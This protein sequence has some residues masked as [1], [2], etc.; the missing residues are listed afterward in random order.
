MPRGRRAGGHGFPLLD[1]PLVCA[2]RVTS[3]TS[4]ILKHKCFK[5]YKQEDCSDFQN[6]HFYK[7][8]SLKNLGLSKTLT[9]KYKSVMEGPKACVRTYVLTYH[10]VL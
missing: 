8:I 2:K 10:H 5:T 7:N 3:N 6:H 1:T 9:Y 4:T